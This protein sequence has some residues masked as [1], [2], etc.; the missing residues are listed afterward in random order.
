MNGIEELRHLQG[1][2]PESRG[3]QQPS[4]E[5]EVCED[6]WNWGCLVYTCVKSDLRVWG[7]EGEVWPGVSLEWHQGRN[8]L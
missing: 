3:T 8:S 2:G 4:V 6:M 1:W 7:S 5:M